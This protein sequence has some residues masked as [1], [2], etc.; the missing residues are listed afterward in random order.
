M[1]RINPFVRFPEQSLQQSEESL[2]GS[3]RPRPNGKPGLF[4]HA[5]FLDTDRCPEN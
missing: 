2:A 5:D 1:I 4:S 3:E